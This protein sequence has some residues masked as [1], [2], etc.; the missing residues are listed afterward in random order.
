MGY[1]L[2]QQTEIMNDLENIKKNCLKVCAFGCGTIGKGI[3]Y[4]ILK[5]LGLNLGCYCDNDTDKWGKIK[6]GIKC[7]SPNTLSQMDNIACI[8]MVSL[9]SQKKI[10]EQLKRYHIPIIITYH[11]L[12]VLDIVINRFLEICFQEGC[13]LD[14]RAYNKKQEHQILPISNKKINYMQFIPV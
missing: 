6:D 11:E 7:I 4:D 1:I 8:V 3:G 5:F 14:D 13:R 10:M 12:V 9:S 2:R